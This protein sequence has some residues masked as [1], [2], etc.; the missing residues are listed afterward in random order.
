MAEIVI[1]YRPREQFQTYHDRTE[2]FAKIVAHRRFG[3]TVGCIND[4]IK[5]ALSVDCSGRAGRPPRYAYIAP[6]YT[7]AK[8]V[9]WGYLKHF[10][11]PI[12]GIETSESELRVEYPNGARI[13]LYGADNY[14]R[15]RGL[16]HDGVTIDEPAQMDPRAW[17]EVI[18][19]TLS[20]Y[21]GW[22]T[23]IGTPA[24]RDWFYKIDRNEDGTPADGWFRLILKASE[25]GIIKPE[26]LESLKAGLTNDQYEREFEC[27]FDAAIIG[28]YYAE[29]MAKARKDGRIGKVAADPLLPIRAFHDIGGAGATSDA[30]TIWIVQWV[31]QEIRVLDYYEST[32][33]VL[34]YHVNW[35]RSRGYEKAI[36]YLPHDG[37]NP[38]AIQGKRYEDH[39]REAGFQVEP[40]VKNQGKGAAMIRVEALRRLGDKI[41]WNEATTEPGRNAIVHYHEKRDEERNVG[42]GPLHDWSSHAADSLGMMACCYVE[43]SGYANFNRTIAYRNQGYA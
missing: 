39:W 11:S 32:G 28:A 9:A 8:D 37:V 25:T 33:Q 42:L 41:W 19:P 10:S 35:M 20:D 15:L 16:Y 17:P 26:E 13:R 36:N 21:A 43:P 23:F 30:Y 4:M 31:Q 18:R 1:P 38:D 2:R 14:D 12:P 22:G 24:G 5:A 27:S 40:S 34:S 3:K 29:L 7:Q 6:T